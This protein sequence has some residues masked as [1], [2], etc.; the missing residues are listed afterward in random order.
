M[1]RGKK[2]PL[3]IGVTKK[4]IDEIATHATNIGIYTVESLNSGINYFLE[5]NRIVIAT[6]RGYIKADIS[7][8]QTVADEIPGIIED[9]LQ[10]QREGNTLMNSRDISKMLGV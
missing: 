10:Y 9:F 8:M 1:K 6:C 7:T 2:P 5:D 4:E 3:E